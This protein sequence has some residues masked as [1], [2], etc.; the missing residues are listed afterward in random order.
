[1]SIFLLIFCLMALSIA[2]VSADEK[3]P[4]GTEFKDIQDAIDGS[5]NDD[6]IMLG[7]D[8]YISYGNESS[9]I[10]SDKSISVLHPSVNGSK[11]ITV[12]NQSNGTVINVINKNIIIQGLSNDNRATLNAN[13]LHSIFYVDSTSTVTFKYINFV[14]GGFNQ[15]AIISYG[16][17][18]IED[19]TFSNSLSNQ[20]G[21]LAIFSTISSNTIISDCTFINNQASSEGGAIYF[22]GSGILTISNSVF[23]G[24]TG[25][26]GGAIYTTRPTIISSSNFTNNVATNDGGAI[27]TTNSLNIISGSI[28]GNSAIYGSG[29]YNTGTLRLNDVSLTNN[30][31]QIISISLDAPNIVEEGS[32]L[33]VSSSLTYGDNVANAIYT[34]NN[35]VYID[36]V[37]ASLSDKAVNKTI[38]LN[39]DN[40]SYNIKTDSNGIAK[41]SVD[42]LIVSNLKIIKVTVSCSDAGK[43]FSKIKNLDI[44]AENNEIAPPPNK[45]TAKNKVNNV[46]SKK[47]PT[48]SKA[49]TKTTT[50]SKAK[51]NAYIKSKKSSSSKSS[52]STKQAYDYKNKKMVWF[53]VSSSATISQ[54]PGGLRLL[55]TTTTSKKSYTTSTKT[56]TTNSYN[57]KTNTN[58]T[59]KYTVLYNIKGSKSK[60]V[61][62]TTTKVQLTTQKLDN[63]YLDATTNAEVN[64]PHIIA[65]ANQITKGVAS[66]D[67]YTKAKLI[68]QWVQQNIDYTLDANISAVSIL[69]QKGSN[70][71]YKAYCVGFSNVMAS[72]CRAVGVPVEY[73]AIFFFEA[74]QYPFQG[75]E[76]H[77]YTKVYVDGQWL[78]ADAATVG[79]I[80]PLNYQGYLQTMATQPGGS[81]YTYTNSWD[82][83]YFVCNHHLSGHSD[84]QITKEAQG[85][86]VLE[87]FNLSVKTT[88]SSASAAYNIL[89][90]YATANGY[91]ILKN[92]Y[93]TGYSNYMN[94]NNY[95]PIWA[96]HFFDGYSGTF[97]GYMILSQSGI[98]YPTLDISQYI[99][100]GT[101]NIPIDYY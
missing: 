100:P 79:F 62:V 74:D 26:N 22:T 35:N 82:Y 81:Y 49:V 85:V 80:A 92:Y 33:I 70:G 54:Y 86:P 98:L 14:N 7:N 21:A 69:S 63:P 45:G 3:T 94:Q 96:F 83:W 42:I 20:G 24:N 59:V 87:Y 41:F 32:P 11:D 47:K 78:F 99:T 36:D 65:L 5:V 48:A 91:L 13:N 19:C 97:L 34:K 88:V 75:H 1:M 90:P 77:V 40:K 2:T 18:I 16:N 46:N 73:H 89:N 57:S 51:A 84:S 38:T 52:K 8:T 31:A 37:Q 23:N 39:V 29:I 28:N 15:G 76:G 61:K 4:V 93:F 60:V 6:I 95:I 66:T 53:N 71:H 44:I 101:T 67:Y 10:S 55:I 25:K 50:L 64:N 9:L 17:I 72:L 12:G 43:T 56:K 27:Y 58:T 68:Y 30:V